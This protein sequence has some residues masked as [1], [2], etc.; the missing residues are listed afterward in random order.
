MDCSPSRL[1]RPWDF[2][3]KNPGAGAVSSSI[4]ITDL[5]AAWSLPGF[6]KGKGAGRRPGVLDVG[7]ALWQELSGVTV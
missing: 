7:G 3:G 2:P 5:T 4:H 6:S 1:L